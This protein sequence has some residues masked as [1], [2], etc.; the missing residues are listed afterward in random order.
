M[1]NFLIIVKRGEN[2]CG[3]YAP[4][5]PGCIATGKTVEE[6]IEKMR[7]ALNFQFE[8]LIEDGDAL[9]AAKPFADHSGEIDPATGDV[10][11]FVQIH[12]EAVAA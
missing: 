10:F 12:T 9:P 1:E 8:G 6:T 5:V 2:N 4:D 3:A 11:A 7:E